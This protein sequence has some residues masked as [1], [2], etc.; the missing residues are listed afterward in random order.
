MLAVVNTT[1]SGIVDLQKTFL[2]NNKDLKTF[3]F[4]S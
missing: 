1:I 3:E 4:L 2:Y